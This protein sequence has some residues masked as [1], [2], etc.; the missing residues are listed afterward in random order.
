M[1]NY[2]CANSSFPLKAMKRV[3]FGGG[4]YRDHSIKAVLAC[5]DAFS[6]CHNKPPALAGRASWTVC[7]REG[8]PQGRGVGIPLLHPTETLQYPCMF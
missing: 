1:V 6:F 2:T 4:V 8:K 5:L 3:F 7:Y